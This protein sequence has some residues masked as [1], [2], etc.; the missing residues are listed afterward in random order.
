MITLI[1]ELSVV[2]IY[3]FKRKIS[4]K[5]IVYALV[6]NLISLSIVWFVFPL[7]NIGTLFIILI[8]ETFAVLFESYFIYYFNKKA[9]NLK[10]AFFLSL[11]MN[12]ISFVLGNIIYT[13]IYFNLPQYFNFY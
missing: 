11:G 6:A 9:L 7:I 5:I 1:L 3:A 4:K 2:S 10:Q 8:S 12:I 13:M